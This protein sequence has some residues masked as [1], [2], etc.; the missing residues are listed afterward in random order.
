[1]SKDDFSLPA[2]IGLTYFCDQLVLSP[3]VCS[4]NAP[5]RGNFGAMMFAIIAEEAD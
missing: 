3:R 4:A 2:L 1:M 5:L